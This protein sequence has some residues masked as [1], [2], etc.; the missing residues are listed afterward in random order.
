MTGR[1]SWR[2]IHGGAATGENW[3][4]GESQQPQIDVIIYTP[5]LFF[6]CFLYGL[7]FI[8]VSYFIFKFN[9]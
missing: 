1:Q 8:L 4:C 7:H 9:N 3:T 6:L 5:S 2:A